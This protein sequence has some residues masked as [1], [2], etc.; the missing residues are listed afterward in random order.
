MN[1][2]LKIHAV[3]AFEPSRDMTALLAERA[4]L[5]QRLETWRDLMLAADDGMAGDINFDP[6]PLVARLE[7]VDA[8]I[9]ILRRRLN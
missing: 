7:I 2:D 9:T 6:E 3:A 8:K 4:T 5:D 1:A